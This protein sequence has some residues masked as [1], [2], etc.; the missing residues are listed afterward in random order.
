MTFEIGDRVVVTTPNTYS[1]GK[2]C[3]VV[4]VHGTSSCSIVPDG[5]STRGWLFENWE[6]KK[7]EE[8]DK[9]IQ[10]LENIGYKVM[11]TS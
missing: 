10:M 1:C 5:V 8:V 6:I 7:L 4:S 2:M 11:K 3:T 9:A